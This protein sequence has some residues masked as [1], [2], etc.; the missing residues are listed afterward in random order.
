MNNNVN[1]FALSDNNNK[2]ALSQRMAE[3]RTFQMAQ[4]A[5]A[6]PVEVNEPSAIDELFEKIFAHLL[7]LFH[8]DKQLLKSKSEGRAIEGA[9]TCLLDYAQDSLANV[10]A[11]L[12]DDVILS[13]LAD[14]KLALQQRG[15]P[16]NYNPKHV[17][18]D[19]K[20]RDMVSNPALFSQPARFP[21]EH[22][23]KAYAPTLQSIR[24]FCTR[25]LEFRKHSSTSRWGGVLEAGDPA[26]RQAGG[27]IFDN[28]LYDNDVKYEWLLDLITST[29]TFILQKIDAEWSGCAGKNWVKESPVVKMQ[30][31]VYEL[32]VI[33]VKE[34][35]DAAI[36]ARVARFQREHPMRQ[37]PDAEYFL[38]EELTQRNVFN[39]PVQLRSVDETIKKFKKH[40]RVETERLLKTFRGKQQIYSATQHEQRTLNF[41]K[42]SRM[43]TQ[44]AAEIERKNGETY[45][46]EKANEEL[47]AEK[48]EMQ[49]RHDTLVQSQAN[50][51]ARLA[52]VAV[53]AVNLN[54]RPPPP[55]VH[56]QG[57]GHN[58]QQGGGHNQ[59]QG[60]GHNQQQGGGHNQQQGSNTVAGGAVRR[61][62]QGNA[63]Q[64]GNLSQGFQPFVASQTIRAPCLREDQV[65][66][67][68]ILDQ[69]PNGDL[70]AREFNE[71][72]ATEDILNRAV[73]SWYHMLCGD[74]VWKHRTVIFI[75]AQKKLLVGKGQV[76][77]ESKLDDDIISKAFEKV[78]QVTSAADVD[79]DLLK[80]KSMQSGGRGSKGKAVQ[81]LLSQSS[82]LKRLSSDFEATSTTLNAI[83]M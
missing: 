58:Q 28:F 37:V 69:E 57:G 45:R 71:A 24:D 54:A 83:V 53:P 5:Q 1:P 18:P 81:S 61:D 52:R 26:K 73:F 38:F 33:H 3:R 23:R 62:N 63:V 80:R 60:G 70:V 17:F 6:A 40:C 30:E 14:P 64:P 34:N 27:H 79:C 68:Y 13:K 4:A 7:Q 56:N 59:Q 47:K 16:A 65:S 8:A 22:T 11:C 66:T 77:F 21:S 55:P 44:L 39:V 10:I 31:F 76:L 48:Q 82:S 51:N 25:F 72:K 20:C 46:L 41:N 75:L 19:S 42:I 74:D 12:Q 50:L 32:A 78:F 9:E 15:L 35:N 49:E 43:N 67:L 29:G 36:Q 2:S